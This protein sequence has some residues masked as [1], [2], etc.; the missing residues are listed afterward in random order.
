M[1]ENHAPIERFDVVIAGGGPAGLSTGIVCARNGLRTLLCDKEAFPIDKACGEG[2]MPTGIAHLEALGVREYLDETRTHPFHGVRYQAP[3]GREAT[4]L[5]AQGRGMGIRRIAL[6]QALLERLRTF[7]SVEIRQEAPLIPLGRRPEGIEVAVG[8]A[9]LLARLLVGADGMNSSIRRWAGLTEKPGKL[10]RWGARQ[11]FALPPWSSYVEVIWQPGVEAY[12]TPCGVNEVGIAFL[13]R[14]ERLCGIRGGKALIASLLSHFPMLRDRL[15]DAPA[16][17]RPRA[18]GPLHRPSRDVIGEGLLLIG[19][20]AGYLDAITGEGISLATAE[21]LAFEKHVVPRLVE[22]N[23]PLLSREALAPYRNAHRAIVSPYL[24]MTR[25]VL[26]L[27]RAPRLAERAIYALAR[28][29]ALF[30]HLLEANMGRGRLSALPARRIF[31]FLW[32]LSLP[33]QGRGDRRPG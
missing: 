9:R 8:G 20:A 27:H 15:G 21:A 29:P 5:F 31:S 16:S 22:G 6:S 2:I 13:W 33:R 24:R 17:S 10:K 4:G 12:I 28:D 23:A 1:Q 11:H 30:T 3:D 32:D 18:V 14:P 26:L 7:P 19:D 25:L